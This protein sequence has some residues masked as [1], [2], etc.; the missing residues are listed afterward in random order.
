MIKARD[1][2][3]VIN[4]RGNKWKRSTLLRSY[5]YLLSAYINTVQPIYTVYIRLK[6]N[7]MVGTNNRIIIQY[8]YQTKGKR[9]TISNKVVNKYYFIRNKIIIMN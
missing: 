7:S 5:V 4:K 6:W 1:W 9:K 3:E 2:L 8:K